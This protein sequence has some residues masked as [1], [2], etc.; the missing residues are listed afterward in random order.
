MN[1]LNRVQTRQFKGLIAASNL[2]LVLNDGM[3]HSSQFL[4]LGHL[5]CKVLFGFEQL[6]TGKRQH[7]HNM[8]NIKPV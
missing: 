5:N 3:S 4:V 2:I 1:Q 8:L 7:R 6:V